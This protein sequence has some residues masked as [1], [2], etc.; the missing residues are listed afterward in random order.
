MFRYRIFILAGALDYQAHG[1][2][3]LVLSHLESGTKAVERLS[4]FSVALT[5][6]LAN[7][8]NRI[9]FPKTVQSQTRTEDLFS[10]LL[11]KSNPLNKTMVFVWL[12][13]ILTP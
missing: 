6:L 10:A 3:S 2:K 7:I 12:L 8:L 4:S 1:L 9:L 5:T 13:A 11:P